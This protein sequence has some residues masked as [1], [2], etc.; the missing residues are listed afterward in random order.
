[1]KRAKLL[2]ISLVFCLGFISCSGQD[3]AATTQKSD[4]AAIRMRSIW[5]KDF[6]PGQL[7]AHYKKH[8]SEFANITIEEYLG[9]AR[10][11]LNAPVDRD[12]LEKVRSNG[13][14]LHYR[15]STGEF[16]VMTSSG[17]IRT[18]F[19]TNYSYWMRQ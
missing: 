3:N 15:V 7:E 16:A 18:Y 4:S 11:L 9:R 1:M 17:R 5:A 6:A 10:S 14:I 13:D 8:K 19:K 2:F 12:V